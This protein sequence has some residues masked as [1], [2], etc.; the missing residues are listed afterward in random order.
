MEL[1]KIEMSQGTLNQI[2]NPYKKKETTALNDTSEKLN[3]ELMDTNIAT[4]ATNTRPKSNAIQ[5]CAALNT[6]KNLRKKL[7]L[8]DTVTA[9]FENNTENVPK[10]NRVNK[11][12]NKSR[13]SKLNCKSPYSTDLQWVGPMLDEPPSHISR[14]WI[15][16]VQSL[17]ISDNFLHFRSLL[18]SLKYHNSEFIAFTETH[19]SP[20]NAYVRENLAASFH[21]VN[22]EG[23]ISQTNTLIDKNDDGTR[24]YGGVMSAVSGALSS[25]FVRTTT[26]KYGRY[27]YTDF[28][29]K[30]HYLRVYV[31]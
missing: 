4:G 9:T 25:R 26:E 12:S 21:L 17:D 8:D 24:Q 3:D 29:G 23:S 15:Q 22:P 13:Q 20:Y 18:H 27:Q 11:N 7:N 30:D 31:V 10:P 1:G 2:M 19:L 14:F 28:F 16:N 5:A 6:I